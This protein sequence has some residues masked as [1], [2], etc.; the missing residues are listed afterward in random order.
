MKIFGFEITRRKQYPMT[1]YADVGRGGWYPIVNEPYTG[2]W[3]RNDEHYRHDGVMSNAIVFRCV[4]LIANDIAK[5]RIR[6]VR[7]DANGI[8]KEVPQEDNSAFWPVLR[9]P[10]GY[11]NRIQFYEQWLTSKLMWG[12]TYILKKRD[13]RNVVTE[14]NILEPTRVRPLVAPNGDVFYE[15]SADNLSDL[16]DRATVPA[17]EVIHDRMNTF[18][19][20]LSGLS[21]I[22]AAGLTA[23]QSLRI[24]SHSERFFANAARP[25]GLIVPAQGSIS[26][27]DGARLK[28][29]FQQQFSG[30]N[31][32]RLALLTA[33]LKY[34]SLGMNAV[35]AQLID[36]LKWTSETICSAFGVPGYKVG[37]G[38]SPS[39]NNIE[40]LER[41]Y[42]NDCLQV[43]IESIELCLDEGLELPKPY[44][45]EFDLDDLLRMDAASMVD[46]IGKA[47]GAGVLTPDEGRRK[48]NYGPIT[49][50]DAAYLQ[51]QNYSLEALAKRDA[52]A[53]PFAPASQQPGMQPSQPI[54]TPP[55]PVQAAQHL[56]REIIVAVAERR[57][58]ENLGLLEA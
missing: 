12:N 57:L 36:Q 3:Q 19:H 34:E 44:G 20:P 51:Q 9:R 32:G 21:P 46:S 58:R 5:M 49:G 26:K 27:D 28:E 42:Y 54:A 40:A 48:L 10:N 47:V 2:A 18:Y 6:L 56:P 14:L 45:T 17:S 25:G 52:L 7:Q 4:S 29:Q 41:Q 43:L 39:Y 50:G 15:L 33:A 8:W 53:D 37:V 31:V 55:E 23:V 24:Q 1:S 35:D 38:P 22:Y 13:Q 11:Q 16:Q 30:A